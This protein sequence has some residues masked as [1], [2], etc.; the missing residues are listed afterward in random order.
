MS[1]I[2]NAKKVNWPLFGLKVWDSHI[3]PGFERKGIEDRKGYLR[4]WIAKEGVTSQNQAAMRM[5]LGD[6]EPMKPITNPDGIPELTTETWISLMDECGVERATLM[7]M[8]TITDPYPGPDGKMTQLRWYCPMAYIKEEFLDKYPDRFVG[9]AGCNVKADKS[10]KMESLHKAKEFGFLGVKIHTASAGYPNDKERCYPVYEKCV[11]LGLHVEIHTGQEEIP[12]TRAKYQDPVYIDDIAVD[13]PDLPIYQ[14]HCGIMNNPRQA[15]WNVFR[16]KN[17]YT[18]ISPAVLQVMNMPY[19]NNL[20]HIKMLEAVV[21]NKVFFGSD[22]PLNMLTYKSSIEWVKCLPL[23]ADFKKKLLYDNA[24]EFY[25]GEWRMS[26]G[27]T[28]IN[29]KE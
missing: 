20:E 13:F 5:A 4:L 17:V 29:P 3:H 23:S 22:A 8:D 14:L 19:T 24:K 21:P 16:H 12:G 15:I 2:G 7:G 28:S 26:L 6:P 27:N 18:D 9:I 25:V 11:E 1:D 10:E